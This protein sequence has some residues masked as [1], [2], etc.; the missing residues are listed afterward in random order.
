MHSFE[1]EHKMDCSEGQGKEIIMKMRRTG[2]AGRIVFYVI[3]TVFV[4]ALTLACLIPFIMVISG[5]FSDNAR[6]MVEGYS[7]LPRGF[8]LNA[9]K[10]V[11]ENP[12]KIG[13][14][15]LVS[16][17]VT[18]V[19][20]T[21]S[22]LFTSM[23][24]YVLSRPDFQY[25]SH[26]AFFMYFTTL[27]SGGTIPWYLITRNVLHLNNTIW[28]LIIPGLIAPF[29]IFLFRN[30]LNSISH[31]FVESAR[32]DGAGEFRIYWQIIMPLAKPAVATIALFVGLSYWNDWFR[33][34][35]LIDDSRKYPLQY[36]LVQLMNSAKALVD[37]SIVREDPV[38]GETMKLAMAIV[39]TGPVLLFYPFAQRYIVG[40]ITIGG[41]KG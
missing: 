17:L 7:I 38:P 30:F 41:V 3:G 16:I 23:A 14:A 2:D 39:T 12:D 29:N 33:A 4:T 25:A 34:S 26:F 35:L 1:D 9:Y 37:I 19:G 21:L 36:V 10:T 22:V 6:I 32:I 20:T 31:A 18:L 24:G 5:S 27:F 11:F 28:A 15:Y 8:S 13:R 40:G